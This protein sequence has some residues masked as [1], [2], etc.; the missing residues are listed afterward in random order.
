MSDNED[1]VG[2][3]ALEAVA[4]AVIELRGELAEVRGLV[5]ARP[6]APPPTP[7]AV[8]WAEVTSAVVAS[9]VL[10]ELAGWVEGL[11]APTWPRLRAELV[12]C[13][14]RHPDLVQVLLDLHMAWSTSRRPSSAPGLTWDV[15]TRYVPHAVT[16]AQ[17]TLRSC[18]S[19]GHKAPAVEPPAGPTGAE[20][21]AAAG[22]GRR[23]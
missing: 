2:V 3:N 23:V 12:A 18:R 13:W 8:V 6:P 14:P 11:A 4:A 10:R 15:H 22:E 1:A 17:G 9:G 7:A 19:G 20:L 5:E 16:I 21:D